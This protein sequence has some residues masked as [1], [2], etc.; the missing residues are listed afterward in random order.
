MDT[1]Y[2]NSLIDRSTKVIPGGINSSIRKFP[3]HI[4]ARAE[5]AYFWDQNGKRYVDYLGAYGPVVL[6]YGCKPVREKTKQAI[7]KYDLYGMGSS[8]PEIL[9]AEK[10]CALMGLDE[11]LLCSGGSEA[12]YHALRA[13]RAYTGRKKIIKM[14]GAFHGWHDYVLING[15]TTPPDML[16]KEY[17]TSAGMLSDATKHTINCRINDLE[18]VRARCKEFEGDVAAIIIDPYCTSLGTMRMDD[19]FVTGL[20][21]ICDEQGIV[22]IFDEIVTGFRIGLGGATARFEAKPDLVCLGKAIA[23]GFPVA[24]VGGKRKFMETYT[25]SANGRTNFQ[26]TYYGHPVLAAA[27]LAT[28]E[29]LERPGVFEHIDRIGDMLANGFNDINNRLGLDYHCNNCGSMMGFYF[30]KGPY[31]NF[32]QL[33][34][35]VDQKL[36]CDFRTKMNERGHYFAVGPYMRIVTSYAHTE[37]D[38]AETLQVMEEVLKELKK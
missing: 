36:S 23:N 10:V 3:G 2:L 16:G 27:A 30:G 28:V 24:A 32:D 12:S 6:G 26:A 21:Q 33:V 25:T 38:I 7:D 14:E 9:L 20:R 37:A 11:L 5:G 34:T 1:G 17:Q 35:T 29:E 19:G 15:S 18:S 8:E 4:T 31:K 22:F 13:A